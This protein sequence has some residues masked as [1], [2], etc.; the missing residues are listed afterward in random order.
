M[1]HVVFHDWLLFLSMFPG[2]IH[3]AICASAS[4]LF[5]A[6]QYMHTP[7][8]C[9]LSSVD[10][11]LSYVVCYEQC[12]YGYQCTS[13]CVD[14]Y[15]QLLRNIPRSRNPRPHGYSVFTFLRNVLVFSKVAELLPIL[16]RSVWGFLFSTT[17]PALGV[18]LPV[19]LHLSLQ[20][21]LTVV[22]SYTFSIANAVEYLFMCFLPLCISSLEKCL[23][24]LP[25]F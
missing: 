23:S 17:S 9:I 3:V 5:V 8:L 24:P 10:G 12:Y 4:F 25:T 11:H 22:L 21:H 1:S 16:T 2:F 6:E 7:H 18:S 20:W 15:F 13:F 14:V 19:F